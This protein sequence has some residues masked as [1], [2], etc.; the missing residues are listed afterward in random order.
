MAGIC[1][2]GVDDVA[3]LAMRL[4]KELCVVELRVLLLRANAAR[5]G[6][7]SLPW[8]VH[9]LGVGSEL[10][11]LP[12]VAIGLPFDG[13]ETAWAEVVGPEGLRRDVITDR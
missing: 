1:G 8:Y 5:E 7:R 3:F 13:G 2:V 4:S 6:L 12:N 10:I 11:L 9:A